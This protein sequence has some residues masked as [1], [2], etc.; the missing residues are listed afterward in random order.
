MIFQKG[1]WW[2]SSHTS[3][4]FKTRSEAEAFDK[5]VPQ[6]EEAVVD[7]TGWS[8]IEKLRGV[9]DELDEYED[10]LDN[11]D[12]CGCDPCECEWNSAEET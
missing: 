3:K 12:D 2:K 5:D 7:T 6:P 11:C 9:K 10:N 1:D 8:P 4:K